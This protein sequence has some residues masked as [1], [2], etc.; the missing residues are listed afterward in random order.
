[1]GTVTGKA[2]FIGRDMLIFLLYLAISINLFF[3]I[4]L[5]F[6]FDYLEEG[7]LCILKG[8]NPFN[9]YSGTHSQINES[10]FKVVFKFI[11]KK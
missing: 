9:L 6:P 2:E 7:I 4:Y 10:S 8:N 3:E 5:R 11:Q 1:M